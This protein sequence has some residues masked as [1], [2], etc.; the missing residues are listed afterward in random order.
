MIHQQAAAMPPLVGVVGHSMRPAKEA[1]CMRFRTGR[2]EVEMSYE[3][4]GRRQVGQV[5]SAMTDAAGSAGKA[6]LAAA[7][8]AQELPQY[9]RSGDPQAAAG[10]SDLPA[11]KIQL[12]AGNSGESLPEANAWYRQLRDGMANRHPIGWINDVLKPFLGG[13][14]QDCSD[15]A[16][17][18][19]SGFKRYGYQSGIVTANSWHGSHAYFY[20][21]I[22][23]EK[24]Y[25]DTWDEGRS[26]LGLTRDR[27][28]GYPNNISEH[29]F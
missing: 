28:P 13:V 1:R 23:G 25:G 26:G 19:A 21:I 5:G 27:H 15:Q 20:V 10:S 6:T 8:P 9:G 29:P 14:P 16:L 4:E 11:E 24:Y 2:D 22:N 3:V 12:L 18:M 17:Y 7:L